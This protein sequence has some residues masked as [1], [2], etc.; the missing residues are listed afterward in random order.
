MWILRR[1]GRISCVHAQKSSSEP[2]IWQ[3]AAGRLL[4]H[5]RAFIA[6]NMVLGFLQVAWAVSPVEKDKALTLSVSILSE[7]F[8]FFLL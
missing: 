2:V 4:C 1:A 7:C 3:Q 8:L 5:A 6:F